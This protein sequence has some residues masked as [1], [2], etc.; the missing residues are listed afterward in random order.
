MAGGLE[1]I[2]LYACVHTIAKTVSAE[3]ASR[4]GRSAK[5]GYR[6]SPI[7]L[8][9]GGSTPLLNGSWEVYVLVVPLLLGLFEGLFWVA[10]HGYRE[11]DMINQRSKNKSYDSLDLDQLEDQCILRGGAL[12]AGRRYGQQELVSML[13][14]LDEKESLKRFQAY[15]VT[16]TILASMIVISLTFVGYDRYGAVLGS[17][18]SL[19]AVSIPISAEI[20]DA[21]V[22]YSKNELN[23]IAIDGQITSA[24]YGNMC[25]LTLWSMRVISLEYGG[26][27]LLGAMVAV[28]TLLGFLIKES[29]EKRAREISNDKTVRNEAGISADRRNWLLGNYLTL[30]GTASMLAALILGKYQ[31]CLIAYVVFECGANGILRPME[32]E[33]A[34]SRLKGGDAIGLRERIKFRNHS[35][36]LLYYSLL[37]LIIWVVAARPVNIAVLLAPALILAILFCLHNIIY[38]NVLTPRHA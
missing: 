8:F 31:I 18:L 28:S 19:I 32:I 37:A 10:F 17:L 6:I 25:F 21:R 33:I 26:V 15:E 11:A 5:F 34:G 13:K 4:S 27:A 3:I 7:F 22:G 38:A 1:G 9:A 23:G 24:S 16:S 14:R 2:F 30:I 12:E 35:K 29:N 20:V 36:A